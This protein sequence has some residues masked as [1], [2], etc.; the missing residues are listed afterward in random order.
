MPTIFLSHRKPDADLAK[1]L[2][3]DLKIA[4]HQVWFDESEINIGDSIFERINEG[5]KSTS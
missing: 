1:Q 3:E 4:G 5:L 2:A